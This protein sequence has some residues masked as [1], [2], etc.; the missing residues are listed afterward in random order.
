MVS[1]GDALDTLTVLSR[2]RMQQANQA[3]PSPSLKRLSLP[4]QNAASP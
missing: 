3:N 2:S 4:V 1:F